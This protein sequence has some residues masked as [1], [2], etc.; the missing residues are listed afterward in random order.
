MKI[1]LREVEKY[2]NRGQHHQVHALRGVDLDVRRGELVVF[3]GPSGSGKST[4]LLALLGQ[5]PR[6]WIPE[7][8]LLT[9]VSMYLELQDREARFEVARRIGALA[10]LRAVALDADGTIWTPRGS[11]RSN[12]RVQRSGRNSRGF[13]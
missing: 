8:S 1:E 5:A 2:Y 6:P 3:L 4:I 13:S 11:W 10:V 12:S 9:I 7:D